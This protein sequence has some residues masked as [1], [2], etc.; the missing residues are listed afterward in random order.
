MRNLYI[1]LSI[2]LLIPLC[3]AYTDIWDTIQGSSH[4]MYPTIKCTNKVE[5]NFTTDVKLND[6]IV[7]EDPNNP[8]VDYYVLHRIISNNKTHFITKGD[9]NTYNDFINHGW[10]VKK[11]NVIGLVINII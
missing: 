10:A 3:L 8:T 5:I 11:T 7:F 6:I 2:F 1:F 4:S 9:N